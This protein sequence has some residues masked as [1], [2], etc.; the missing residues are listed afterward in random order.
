MALLGAAQVASGAETGDLLG[1][2][3]GLGL[4]I[5]ATAM[6]AKTT[7]NYCLRKMPTKEN[8]D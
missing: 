3:I 6:I 8:T 4:V 7:V 1:L 2:S 5:L